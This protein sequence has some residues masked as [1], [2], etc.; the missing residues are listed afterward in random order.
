MAIYHLSA[1][2]IT[3]GAGHSAVHAAAYRARADLT[4]ERTG[5]KHDYSRKSGDV[6]F[7]GIYAP[8]DAPGWAHD[9]A[10]LWNHVEAFEKHRRAEL[11]REYEIALFPELTLE[12]NRQAL[13]DLVREN[14]T[15]RGLIADVNI[16]APSKEGDQRNIHAHVMVVTRKLDGSEFVRTKERFEKFSEKEAAKKAE[17]EKL[18]V[19]WERIGNRH[20]ERHG[21]APTLDHRSLEAQGI[22]RAPTIH[23]G[24]AA[25]AIERKGKA[26]ELGSVNRE[27]EAANARVIDLAAERA[28]RQARDAARGQVDDIRPLA[29][30]AEKSRAPDAAAEIQRAQQEAF[31][32]ARGRRDEIRQPAKTAQWHTAAQETVQQRERSEGAETRAGQQRPSQAPEIA[33]AAASEP[34]REITRGTERTVGGIFGGFARMAERVLGGLFS[35]FAGD[36][37]KQTA[38]QVHDRQ[39]AEGN[40]ETQHAQAHEAARQEG[41]TRLQRTLDEIRRSAEARDVSFAQRY[42]TPPTREANRDEGHERERERE[43]DRGYER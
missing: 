35:L 16:H 39:Q 1:K 21:H 10:Q 8:K 26:S 25:T 41:D 6:L 34:E 28:M 24:K 5:L 31:A 2:V 27:I 9:R 38:Q 23:Q 19:N 12:Q 14:F 40:I 11:A 29:A 30:G 32:S 37:P 36:E 20:L 22:E 13:Q 43:R 4:D 18:R 3:R 42:S 33:P 7:S 15:R 17:L